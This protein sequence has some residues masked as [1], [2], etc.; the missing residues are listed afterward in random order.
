M[1]TAPPPSPARVRPTGARQQA[2]ERQPNGN[3][4]ERE[5]ITN[6][7]PLQ[8]SPAQRSRQ[9]STNHRD[10]QR[11]LTNNRNKPRHTTNVRTHNGRPVLPQE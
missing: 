4:G 9:C 11:R 6:K 1:F 5:R 10:E 8:T 2:S 7:P 3:N